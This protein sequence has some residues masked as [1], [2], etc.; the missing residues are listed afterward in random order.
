VLAHLVAAI[1]GRQAA[2]ARTAELLRAEQRTTIA[3]TE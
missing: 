3:A 1:P 2:R